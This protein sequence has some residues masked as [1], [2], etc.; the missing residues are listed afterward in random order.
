M[1]SLAKLK[2]TP[3]RGKEPTVTAEE[4]AEFTLKVPDW[5]IVDR[6]GIQQLERGYK[7][8]NFIQALAFTNRVGEIA[9]AE[10][11]HPKLV[12][13]WGK[14]T[15]TWWTHSIGGLHR[16]DFIMAARADELYQSA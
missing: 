8:D 12:T 6:G 3:I 2:C 1:N 15:V 4:L 16:N 9:E 11:H 13:E 5:Q 14:V 10:N 7:F